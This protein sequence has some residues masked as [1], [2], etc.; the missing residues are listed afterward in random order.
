V[1][2]LGSALNLRRIVCFSLHPLPLLR[3]GVLRLFGLLRNCFRAALSTES[4]GPARRFR[5]A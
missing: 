3:Q 5:D 1:I 4:G 2:H